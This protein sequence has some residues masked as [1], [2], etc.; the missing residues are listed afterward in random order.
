MMEYIAHHHFRGRT[1]CGKVMDIPYG[2]K[3][4]TIG[5]W[6]ATPDGRA[7]CGVNSELGHMY[8]ARNDDGQGLERGKLTWAI[9]Y[10]DRG[11]K[12]TGDAVYRFS[13]EEQ[14]LLVKRYKHFLVEDVP[15]I[16][17]NDSF[18]AAQVPDLW[19]MAA[20]LH[21]EVRR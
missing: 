20:A 12:R 8:F 13:D 5:N 2:A 16:L 6:I 19:A 10:G 14:E 17:F 7:I 15:V 21:I 4:E 9:A 18:F 11:K 3:Y 1:A